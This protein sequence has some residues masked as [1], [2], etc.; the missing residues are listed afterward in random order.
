MQSILFKSR[1][2]LSEAPYQL[3]AHDRM[4]IERNRTGR[5]QNHAEKSLQRPTGQ[6]K[7]KTKRE[8]EI[9]IL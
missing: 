3:E 7:T 8:A 5:T 6:K 2:G 1:H 4:T 9:Q